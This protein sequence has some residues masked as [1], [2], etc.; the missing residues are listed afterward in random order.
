MRGG[1]GRTWADR[2]PRRRSVRRLR[3]GIRAFG[4]RRRIGIARFAVR[5][6]G[7]WPRPALRPADLYRRRGLLGA[8]EGRG[9]HR[10]P[11]AVAEHVQHAAIA[12]VAGGGGAVVAV[13][14]IE[15]R[16]LALGQVD[17]I[18]QAVSRRSAAAL[19]ALRPMR[20]SRSSM[21]SARPTPRS[22]RIMIPRGLVSSTSMGTICGSRT[23]MARAR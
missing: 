4:S 21:P 10:E 5:C 8:A 1:C 18:L 2:A 19:R 3:P 16:L 22:V 12:K 14:E 15:A 20:P 17:F 13:V 11:A 9:G 7:R 23:A 6:V